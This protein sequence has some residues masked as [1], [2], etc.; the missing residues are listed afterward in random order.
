MAKQLKSASREKLLFDRLKQFDEPGLF[1]D[2]YQIPD[3]VQ[4]NLKDDLRPY[5]QGALLNV[6]LLYTSPR[7]RD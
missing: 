7:P 1:H 6:C 3:Y 4:A 5:Q 2:N